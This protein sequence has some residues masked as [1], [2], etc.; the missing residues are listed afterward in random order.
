MPILDSDLQVSTNYVPHL[1]NHI[2]TANPVL[3][4][5]A[6]FT[7]GART[8]TGTRVP[9]SDELVRQLWALCFPS[10]A[11]EVGSTLQDLF[12]VALNQQRKALDEL[13]RREFSVDSE[14]I[15][16]G[17]KGLLRY[18]WARIYTLNI[19]NL[20]EMAATNDV[21]DRS[22]EAISGT[23]GRRQVYGKAGLPRLEVVHLNGM[24]A[25]G[26]DN[27]TFSRDQYAIRLAERDPN[28]VQLSAELVARPAVFVGS[29]VEDT[30][31]WQ[32]IALRDERHGKAE[33]RPRTYLVSPS[34]PK[35][36]LA[37]LA[38]YNFVH[39][40]ATTD[41]FAAFLDR[42]CSEAREE[43]VQRMVAG[44]E[45][46]KR[47]NQI[48]PVA[49]LVEAEAALNPRSDFL[50]GSEPLWSDITG[51]KAAQRE[52]FQSAKDS[53]K[54]H[55]GATS[56]KA[57]AITGTAGVGKSTLLRWAGLW[58]N[59]ELGGCYWIDRYSRPS[60]RDVSEFLAGNKDARILFVEDADGYGPQ[61]SEVLRYTLKGQRPPL[62]IFETRSSK[63][64]GVVD[65]KAIGIDIEID[66][67]T[68]PPLCDSDI[69]GLLDVLQKNN[70]LGRLRALEREE[71]VRRFRNFCGR[72]LL[73]AMYEATTGQSFREKVFAEYT[74]LEPSAKLVYG[75]VATATYFG[76]RP[77][78]DEVVLAIG[79]SANESLG[80]LKRLRDRGILIAIG[81]SFAARHRMVAEALFHH[82]AEEGTLGQYVKML[83]RFA[84]VK[85]KPD[86]KRRPDRI[87]RLLRKLINHDLFVKLVPREEARNIYG[88]Y[89]AALSWN[90]HFWLHRGALEVEIGDLG[91]AENFLG[92][93]LALEPN[94]PHVLVEWSYLLLKKA[95]NADSVAAMELYG[96][97]KRTIVGV[98]T[99]G[100]SGPYPYHVLGD[101]GMKLLTTIPLPREEKV[102]ELT[103]LRDFV[104]RGA[105]TFPGNDLLKALVPE[106]GKAY[107]SLAVPNK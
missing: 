27:V 23:T 104:N 59:A 67:F 30:P 79:E 35:T 106:V 81:D 45:R 54:K 22:I 6:G 75:V 24:L 72:Q 98:A 83:L 95:L 40:P 96:E 37:M 20:V 101:A 34:I 31:L 18:P 92:Q 99:A 3:F 5:G 77:S 73:V 7:L 14:T 58:A 44:R 43:G 62:V 1:R 80:E 41:E 63:L 82:F 2:G 66:E 9:S 78:A 19:D 42:N 64:D 86:P 100:Y 12:D 74:E 93:A 50:M 53:I 69:T 17:Q 88:E 85:A 49:A 13:L 46:E 60:P 57:L 39:L 71:Q 25:D 90:A 32:H 8:V 4:L 51:G 52:C 70:R 33:N 55:V 10:E 21:I 16:A 68:V 47:A 65:R 103:F 15:T 105:A 38:R 29:G 48:Y 97:A 102:T 11:F 107:L 56:P 61:F 26:P 91:R 87:A 84:A 36:R 28:Y 89:E 76:C 94:N